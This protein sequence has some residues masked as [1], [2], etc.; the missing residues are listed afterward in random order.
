[1]LETIYNDFTTKLLPQI[2]EGLT[3][4]KD[5]F[6]DLF[7]RYVHYLIVMDSIYLGIFVLM[8]IAG[9]VMFYKGFKYGIKTDWRSGFP[10]IPL[11]F[12]GF[13]F[14]VVGFISSIVQTSNLVRDIYIPEVRVLEKIQEFRNQ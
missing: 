13:I 4:T 5:Y 11:I 10:E 6:I 7:G 14:A 9:L 1:M 3:I 2:Q 12:I 8:T